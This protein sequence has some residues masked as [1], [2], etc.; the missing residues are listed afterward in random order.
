MIQ[1]YLHAMALIEALSA[2]LGTTSYIWGGWTLDIYQERFLR[3]HADIDCLVIDLHQRF[4]PFSERLPEGGWEVRN[5]LDSYLYG[6]TLSSAPYFRRTPPDCPQWAQVV[7]E[8]V[9]GSEWFERWRVPDE[10]R[11][12]IL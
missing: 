7:E 1:R 9:F 11:R 2:E 5:L 12:R 3:T 6:M 10:P 8:A 4:V